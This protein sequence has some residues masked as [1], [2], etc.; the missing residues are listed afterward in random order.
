MVLGIDMSDW[1]VVVI[2]VDIFIFLFEG[3]VCIVEIY[4]LI[5]EIYYGLGRFYILIKYLQVECDR[6]VE[7]VVDKFIK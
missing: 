1:R 5:V 3:I 7:K 4:Q 6:Q 2:F